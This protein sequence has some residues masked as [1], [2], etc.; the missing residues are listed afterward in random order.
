VE[1]EKPWE[2]AKTDPKHLAE[3]LGYAVSDLRQIASLLAPVLPDTA[4]K[5][6]ATFKNNQV[7]PKVGI[8]F[9]RLGTAAPTHT[10][11]NK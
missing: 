8:L 4:A 6:E 1:A 2:L 9:P 11:F 5:I 3:V 10:R 7:D